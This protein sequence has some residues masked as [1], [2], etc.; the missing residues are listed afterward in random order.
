MPAR[1]VCASANDAKVAE[2]RRLVGPGVDLVP[3]PA[4]VSDIE[5]DAPTLAG[6]A[7]IKA[8]AIAI[9]SGEWA[10][11]DDTGL[12]VDSLGGEPGVRSA[13]FAGPSATDEENRALLLERLAGV[14]DRNATFRTVIAVMSP[15]GEFHLLNGECHGYIAE[16]E[17]GANGFGYDSLFIPYEGDGRTF[18]EMSST[19]KD[20]LSH[21]AR[22]LEQLPRLLARIDGN[23]PPSH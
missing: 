1:L 9:H 20:A 23:R 7:L 11:A 19:E 10:I 21:R 17:R 16:T 18:A 5:E 4:G 8:N 2:I 6:N 12:E 14:S 3:R 13:R 22:A 15:T